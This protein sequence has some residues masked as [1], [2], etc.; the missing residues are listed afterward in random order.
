MNRFFQPVYDAFRLVTFDY[1]ELIHVVEECF[2][3]DC[4]HGLL[5]RVCSC[6]FHPVLVGGM[7]AHELALAVGGNVGVFFMEFGIAHCIIAGDFLIVVVSHQCVDRCAT[8]VQ[9]AGTTSP[10]D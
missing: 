7:V 10:L 8:E 6:L 5:Y 4:S 9:Y 2:L 3:Y 1:F